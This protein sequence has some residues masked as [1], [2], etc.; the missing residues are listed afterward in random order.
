MSVGE[1][2]TARI[3]LPLAYHS[4]TVPLP[5]QVPHRIAS[6]IGDRY[7]AAVA[8]TGV[9]FSH[10]RGGRR[11]RIGYLSADFCEHLNAYLS[12]PLFRMHDRGRFEVFAYSIGPT[13]VPR[14]GKRSR[15]AQTGSST[16][17]TPATSTLP[18]S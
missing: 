13:T 17:A 8:K 2:E 10:G 14:S 4:L 1:A 6:V 18:G 15:A 5:P 3:D 11:I 16:C 12:Y 9:R 7:A